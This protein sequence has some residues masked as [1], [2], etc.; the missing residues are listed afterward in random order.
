MAEETAQVSLPVAQIREGLRQDPEF[1]IQFFLADMLTHPVPDFHIEIFSE[2]T[3]ADVSRLV[4]AIPRAHAKT[5]LAKLCCVWYLLFSDYRFVLYVSG[6]HDLVV[7]YVNDIVSFLETPNFI[8]VFGQVEW[9]KR[10][11]GVGVYKFRIP[12]IDKVCIL[13]GLGSG[14]RIRGI[15]VDNE[16]PQLAVVDDAEDDDDVDTD[17]MRYKLRRWW[18]GAFLKCLNPFHNKIIAAGNLLSS[19]SLLQHLIESPSWR[20]YLYGCLRENGEPLWADMWSI[21]AL[22]ADFREYEDAGMVARWFAEMLNQPIAEGGGV[23]RPEEITYGVERTPGEPEFGFITVDPA[24]S[25][26][27]WADRAAIAAHGWIDEEQYWQVVKYD[28]WRG[29]DTT[30]LYYAAIGL[31]S[32]WGFRVIGVESG[33]MQGVVEHHFNHLR[34][35]NNHTNFI[36][37]PL[38]SGNRRKTERIASWAAQLRASETQ[39]ASYALTR[40][41]YQATHQLLRY[42]PT[43]RKN[44]DDIIDC[45][46]YG[47]QMAS[48]YLNE[49]MRRQPDA[50]QGKST[51]LAQIANC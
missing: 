33:A 47:P 18:F 25:R 32:E 39:S 34:L 20:S 42:E 24:I 5:T 44:D 16:R 36:F 22:R 15:N 41:D 4:I 51:R 10:Q 17:E 35:L 21:E 49:I 7:P 23:I 12:S 3:H 38:K 19:R 6:S 26:E 50:I 43:R 31:A 29:I 28:S 27:R 9:L 46:A 40:G 2:M 37:V 13:R 14:Q 30:K 11:D 48:R 1:F 45:L 8:A